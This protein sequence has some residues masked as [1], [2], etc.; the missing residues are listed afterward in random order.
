[1]VRMGPVCRRPPRQRRVWIMP[2]LF[3]SYRR[4]DSL[5]IT[6]RV[7]DR[8]Q[9]HFG[10][11]AVFM[12]VDTIPLGVD[13]RGYFADWLT[14]CDLVLVIIGPHWLDACHETGERQGTRR[15]DDPADYVR[16]EIT[17]AL[18]RGIPVIPV[19]AGGASMPTV[20]RLPV[21]LADLAFRNAAEVRSG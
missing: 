3:I 5:D 18:S 6:D 16:I 14:G 9:A 21:D 17:E 11:G 8:L 4:E 1:R 7:Y 20:D 2:K 13:F 19:L 10:K 15:L 12:D